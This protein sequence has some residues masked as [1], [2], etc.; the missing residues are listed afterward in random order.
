MDYR[1]GSLTAAGPRT[2]VWFLGSPPLG[3][4]D[5]VAATGAHSVT[6]SL[7]PLVQLV[8]V[9]RMA[10]ALARL[11]GLD[12]DQ[13]RHLT[14]SVILTGAAAASQP[15]RTDSGR[16]RV[17]DPSPSPS[18]QRRGPSRRW[19][20]VWRLIAGLAG[21]T[22][23]LTACSGGSSGGASAPLNTSA[24]V[25]LTWWTGQ[26]ADQE[27]VAEDLAKQ[28]SAAHPNVKMQVSAGAATTDDLLQKLQA[29]F[30][31]DTY[32]D[33]S[34]AFGSWATQLGDSGKTLDIT[35]KVKDPAVKWEEFPE[36]ARATASPKGVTIG[37]PAIVD[38]L[39]VLYNPKLFAAA[40]VPEPTQDWTWDD[41]RADAKKLTD[42]AR[43]IY[44]TAYS[45]SGSEDTTWH[46]WP[47]LWQRGGDVLTED[48]KK[49]AF[50]SQAGVD[51]LE[52]LRQLAVVDKSMYLDQTDE[53]YGPLFVDGHVGMI[54]SGPWQLYDLVQ[55][56]APYKVIQLPGT[57]GNHQT[58]SGPDIWTLYDHKDAN[59]AYWSFEFIKWL[60]SP[61]VD[62]K[63]N[64]TQGNLPLRASASS[65]PEFQ[66]YVKDYPGADV[67]FDNLKNATKPRPTVSGYVE[68]SRYVGEAISKVLQG[69]ETPKQALDDA[70]QKANQALAV[71]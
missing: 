59:R 56:K 61:E 1:H 65:T 58:I 18:G 16:A 7:D 71:G 45:V 27:K 24:P 52:Y 25:T 34:Y 22:L 68:L 55:A 20:P 53:K 21:S 44:G 35:E 43:N 50:N 13:P 4:V 66:Q 14:R 47:L 39:A 10:V 3:L 62:V 23:A 57:N 6:S 8:Q 63:W 30:A 37:F 17:A 12:P 40:G 33:I 19:S 51:S 2:A 69:A 60:T 32:P 5:E 64:L 29:G 46:F 48:Q 28:F 42:P 11:R 70:A 26:S 36:A 67:L 41:F 38:N 15:S 49:A 9:Q 54:I 31:A